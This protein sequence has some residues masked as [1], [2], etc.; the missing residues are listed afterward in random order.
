MVILTFLGIYSM[1]NFV[2]GMGNF[3][4]SFLSLVK[5]G[6]EIVLFSLKQ[7]FIIDR[8]LL[9]GTLIFMTERKIMLP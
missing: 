2:I 5:I 9:I 8:T 1:I 7:N 4:K 3:F 6:I